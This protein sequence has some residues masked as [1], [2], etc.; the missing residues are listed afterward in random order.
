MPSDYITLYT[1][2]TEKDVKKNKKKNNYINKLLFY[3]SQRAF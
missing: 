1:Y 3:S 2:F